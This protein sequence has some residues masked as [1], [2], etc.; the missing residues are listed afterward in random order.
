MAL[1][2]RTIV[3]A[4]VM[5]VVVGSG[6]L[7]VAGV[8]AVWM[9]RSS[10][11]SSDG[12]WNDACVTSDEGV[13]VAG[14][15]SFA[16]ID[17]GSGAIVGRGDGYVNDVACEG[18][19]A[20][21]FAYSGTWTWPGG[22]R[23][24]AVASP[25]GELALALEDGR[26]LRNSRASRSGRISGPLAVWLEGGERQG[27][28]LG[29]GDFGEVGRAKQHPTPDW[30]RMWP[31]RLTRYAGR[32]QP[33]LLLAAGWQ[34][35]RAFSSVEPVPWGFFAVDPASGSVQPLLQ[36]IVS[37]S[38]L[39]LAYRPALDA[40]DDGTTLALAA[41]N[42]S[43]GALAVFRPPATTS[44][45][46]IPLTG[47]DE[48]MRLS[49]APDGSRVAVVSGYRGDDRPARLAVFDTRDG[50]RLWSTTVSTNVYGLALLRDGSLVWAS[51]ARE[52][53]RV[54]LPGGR[55]LWRARAQASAP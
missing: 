1:S 15:L 45:H 43:D 7:M 40:S 41:S 31:A 25:G 50:Q 47:W 42:G 37:D 2:K 14:G 52:A 35:N 39:N 4:L 55:E 53:A 5:A 28:D 19:R 20:V 21:V 18:K 33:R 48:V 9:L 3:V 34:P 11:G 29:P 30:F 49:V 32:P 23:G 54:E 10:S 26:R 16:A 8:A 12:Y 44:V 46:R 51:A 24:P 13:L 17:L 36:P 38:A 6:V 27:W 22:E